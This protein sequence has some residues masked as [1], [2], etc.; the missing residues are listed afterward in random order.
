MSSYQRAPE[1]GRALRLHLNENTGGCSPAVLEAI[2]SLDAADIAFYP[3]YDEV[4]RDVAGHFGLDRAWIALLN[5]LDEGLHA[6]SALA[7]RPDPDG[8]RS[9]IIPEPAFEMYAAC[10]KAAGGVV[11]RIAPRDGF[12]FPQRE[13]A[14]AL[15]SRA[16]LLFITNPDNPTGR[17]VPAS[18]I[19][20]VAAAAPHVT[21][22][23]DEAYI[24]FGG[25]TVLR[26][27]DTQ[28]NL[29]V[30]RTFAKAYGLAALRAGCLIAH[31]DT[32]APVRELLSPYNVNVA[33]AA[34]LRAALRDRAWRDRYIAESERSRQLIYDF[35]D[36]RRIEY[37]RSAA[38]FVLVRVG[39]KAPAIVR[40]LA[41][42]GIFIRD[43]STQ[44]GCAGCV[45][46]TAGL[47]DHTAACLSALGELL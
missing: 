38:N 44:P 3:G 40:A 5:G 22:L 14:Q 13:I 15:D 26:F 39:S 18:T 42:R 45:R 37:Y 7:L 33:A 20:A 11:H 12:R 24:D 25:E 35:C 23:V 4:E 8:L 41:D 19:A 31:P 36:A 6:V 10:T 34:A 1:A 29:I 28:R 2:R 30:G 9:A 27:I 16:R 17:A 47:T 21:V 46:I 32:L 43:R